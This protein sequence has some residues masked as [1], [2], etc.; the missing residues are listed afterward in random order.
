MLQWPDPGNQKLPSGRFVL[1][2]D[3]DSLIF[4]R[5]VYGAKEPG[6]TCSNDYQILISIMYATIFFVALYFAPCAA[7]LIELCQMDLSATTLSGWI[8]NLTI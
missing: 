5:G 7:P 2:K 4:Q 1:L 8:K 3:D 6:R